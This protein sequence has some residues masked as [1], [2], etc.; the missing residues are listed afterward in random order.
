MKKI[1]LMVFVACA[2]VGVHAQQ[3]F[4]AIGRK[5]L[6][7]LTGEQVYTRICQ[8]CHMPDARGAAGA[9]RYPALAGNAKLAS[10]AYPTVMVL[11]GRGNMPA[12]GPMLSDAQV[13]GV[14]NY[15]RSH[16]GNA[17]TDPV[18]PDEVKAFRPPAPPQ[19]KY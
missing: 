12:F 6:S 13:A 9:G 4:D 8:G 18:T 11:N 16:F 10:P 1:F 7:R 15:V 5:D 3:R 17:Y 2:A 19:E 14:V